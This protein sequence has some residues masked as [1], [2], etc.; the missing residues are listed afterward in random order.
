MLAWSKLFKAECKAIFSNVPLLVT[1]FFGVVFYSFLYPLPYAKQTPHNLPI[2]VVDKD[3]SALSR[4]L[5]RMIDATPEVNVLSTVNSVAEAQ[6]SLAQEQTKGYLIVPSHFS[7]QLIMGEIPTLNYGGDGSLFLVFGTIVEGISYSVGTLTASIKV[8][9]SII[10]GDN[11]NH[12]VK[13]YDAIKLDLKPVYNPTIGY[14]NYVVPA[15]FIL[16]LHQTLLIAVGLVGADQKRSKIDITATKPYW[17][18]APLWQLLLVRF[19]MFVAIYIPLSAYYLGAALV[20]YDVPRLADMGDIVLITLPFLLAVIALGICLG[21]LIDKKENVTLVVLLSS[22]PLV[23]LAGF[24]WPTE[25][26]PLLLNASAQFIPSTAAISMYLHS[27]Q[28]GA[29]LSQ[30][31]TQIHQLW[32]L[33]LLY[34]LISFYL[35]SKAR[36]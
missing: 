36:Q 17:L 33:V 29:G 3:N 30:V 10:A 4:Q 19:V 6:D 31:M 2:V 12:A 1:V 15:V 26:I 22:L 11:I 28:M 7:K 34:V 32:A 24:I 16:I 9:Q 13:G 18:I 25:S 5:I 35:L 14:Q 20:Y 21:C 27:N 8:Q 23:F